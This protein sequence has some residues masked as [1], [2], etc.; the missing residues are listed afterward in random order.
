MTQFPHFFK[1]TANMLNN[2]GAKIINFAFLINFF[3]MV[4]K[5]QDHSCT[6]YG[7]F[8][9]SYETIAYLY[10]FAKNFEQVP[11]RYFYHNTCSYISSKDFIAG[12]S[13]IVNLAS[14]SLNF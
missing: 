8:Q 11:F 9:K 14:T 2:L 10:E 12:R 6:F 7:K 13:T 1:L 3:P 4:E 5:S